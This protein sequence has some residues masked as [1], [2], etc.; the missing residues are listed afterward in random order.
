[1][2]KEVLGKDKPESW[3]DW[4]EYET[5]WIQFKFQGSEF[6]LER[7]DKLATGNSNILTKEILIECKI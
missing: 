7:L 5:E 2:V 3:L 4:R 6:D 1:M